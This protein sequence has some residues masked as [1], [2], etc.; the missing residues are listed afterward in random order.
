[1]ARVKDVDKLSCVEIR[2]LVASEK[3][4]DEDCRFMAG[5]FF[6]RGALNRA[7]DFYAKIEDLEGLRRV[8]GAAVEHADHQVLWRLAHTEDLEVGE[9]QW[10]RCAERAE[11]LGRPSVAA[12]VY[13]RLGDTDALSRLPEPWRP[14]VEE[15]TEDSSA[16]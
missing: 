13:R 4:A 1:M 5:E 14:K 16:N 11:E 2:D 8:I 6:E 9:A 3:L 15:D 7:F 10:R 12:F